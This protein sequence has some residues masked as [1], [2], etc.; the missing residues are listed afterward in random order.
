MSDSVELSDHARH[1]STLRSLPAVRED[2]VAEIRDAIANGTYDTEGKLDTAVD[3]L[4]E[5]LLAS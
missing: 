3:R 5:D 4:L 2:R 1:L